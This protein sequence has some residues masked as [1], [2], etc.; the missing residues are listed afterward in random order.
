MGKQTVIVDDLTGELLD[1]GQGKHIPFSVNGTDYEMDLTKANADE[2]MQVMKRYTD[3]A[4]KVESRRPT[5]T[6]GGK[7]KRD[8]QHLQAV[9]TWAREQGMEVSDRGRIAAEIEAAY[10]KATSNAA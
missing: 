7:K 4:T 8:P 3:R 9:R 1:A 10:E 5:P 6:A 2:F